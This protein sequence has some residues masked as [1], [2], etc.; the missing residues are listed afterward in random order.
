M[1]KPDLDPVALWDW[2][3]GITYPVTGEQHAWSGTFLASGKEGLRQRA[4]EFYAQKHFAEH[5]RLP[6]GTHHVSATIDPAGMDEGGDIKNLCCNRSRWF[7][8]VHI[9]YPPASA[10]QPDREPPESAPEP[11]PPAAGR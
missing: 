9:T 11:Q 8:K 6:E 2:L 3:Q 1:R 7:L 10:Y 5:G 4:A